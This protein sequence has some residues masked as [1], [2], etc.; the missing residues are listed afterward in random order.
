MAMAIVA[1]VCL[2]GSQSMQTA[3]AQN[4]KQF[5]LEDLNFG[6]INYHNMVPKNRWTTWWNDNLVHLDVDKCSIVDKSTGKEKTLFTV[7]QF[8]K[9]A[10]NTQGNR[11]L[12]LADA[13]FPYAD[14]PIVMVEYANIRQLLNFKTHKIV[15]TQT[16][17]GFSHS[18]WNAT[19]KA[20]AYVNSD[21]Y[22]LH[23]IDAKGNDHQLSADASRDILYGQSVHR[24]E[25]GYTK[26]TFWSPNG[27]LLAF[28]RMDQS[29]VTDYPL[30]D[31]PDPS[32]EPESG[33]RMA[34]PA[35]VKYPMAGEAMHKVTIGV[36]NLLTDKTIYLKAGDPTDRYFTNVAWSPDSKTVYLFELNRDQNDCRLVSYNAETGDRLAE[37][38]HETDVK[39]VEPQH[40]ILFLP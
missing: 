3:S 28:T 11:L 17:K 15:W 36:Y 14:K 20:T 10:A 27:T 19:T 31:I 21:D 12:T 9:W 4:L 23:V 24:D 13:S 30:V 22:Q 16:T 18:D 2:T 1:V 7:E 38:Y 34:K 37:L 39:Y 8:N 33:T 29:M 32:K 40:P 25:F 6:G 35:P 5:T 26:G